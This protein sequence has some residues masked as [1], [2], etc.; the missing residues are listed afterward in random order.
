[1][2][3]SRLRESWHA[4]LESLSIQMPA[5]EDDSDSRGAM[6]VL[7]RLGRLERRIDPDLVCDKHWSDVKL[8][9]MMLK[10]SL[11]QVVWAQIGFQWDKPL[12]LKHLS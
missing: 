4:G 11:A 2:L 3:S 1:M 5:L 7:L 10:F 8:D 9:W 6:G 12:C